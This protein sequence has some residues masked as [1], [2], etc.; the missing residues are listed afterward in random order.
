M[1]LKK[2]DLNYWEEY[3][4]EQIAITDEMIKGFRDSLSS[5]NE[6]QTADLGD[7]ASLNQ[8]QN[9]T[10]AQISR[11]SLYRKQ[12]HNALIRV[13]NKKFGI[14]MKCSEIA[15]K[16]VYI[17]IDLLKLNPLRTSCMDHQ[18]K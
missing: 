3:F 16:N 12:C 1:T 5:Q 8:E 6:H 11:K 9:D 17:P 2:I 7:F 15:G 13:K 4:L 18:K 14:C 10:Y